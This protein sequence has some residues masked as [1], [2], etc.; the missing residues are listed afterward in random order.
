LARI[1]LL[2]AA[3]K[4]VA[5]WID[6]TFHVDSLSQPVS[7]LQQSPD[8]FYGPVVVDSELRTWTVNN[9]IV[10]VDGKSY[11]WGTAKSFLMWK[12]VVYLDNPNGLGFISEN[13]T[14]WNQPIPD[15]RIP[16]VI[17]PDPIPSMFTGTTK[18]SI[19]GNILTVADPSGWRVGDPLIIPAEQDRGQDGPGGGFPQTRLASTAA[20]SSLPNNTLFAVGE[21]VYLKD[22]AGKLVH[23]LND[24]GDWYTAKIVPKALTAKIT[25]I[26]GNKFTLNKSATVN[27]SDVDVFYDVGP[28]IVN[29]VQKAVAGTGPKARTVVNIEKLGIP[30]K[31]MAVGGPLAWFDK[32]YVELTCD[33]PGTVE[34]FS[35]KGAPCLSIHWRNSVGCVTKWITRR[36]NWGDKGFGLGWEGSTGVSGYHG[37]LKD[38][39][40]HGLQ[41]F[42][43]GHEFWECADCEDLDALTFDLPILATGGAGGSNCWSRRIKHRQNQPFR[44][45]IQWMI[46]YASGKNDGTEDC[47]IDSDSLIPGFE[48]MHHTGGT[49]IRPSGRNAIN[50][51]NNAGG[52]KVISPKFVF[53][54]GC[55][56]PL[57]G[58]PA[59][60]QYATGAGSGVPV[61][62]INRNA[63]GIPSVVAGGGTMTDVVIEQPG[64]L[65][66]R[67]SNLAGVVVD[68]EIV[69]FS[70][71]NLT[72]TFPEKR[73]QDPRYGTGAVGL[74]SY[75]P[76]A[77]IMGTIKVTGE[78]INAQNNFSIFTVGAQV[79]ATLES[80]PGSKSI[81]WKV[82]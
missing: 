31:K 42:L 38:T 79:T 53:D 57:E 67:G 46:Q 58:Y 43:A 40:A 82:S 64:Y 59:L 77:K 80:P 69:N 62:N 30:W 7:M 76:N 20:M 39:N 32:R 51:T 65:D 24:Y 75:G 61:W 9:N 29:A 22:T 36:G 18:G 1:H 44:Q 81:N 63:K 6:G 71:E 60:H 74:K 4:K 16:V 70:L 2:D 3:G 34:L 50:A 25:A 45:Y 73:V 19:V 26:N 21:D 10:Y 15:P 33:G 13:E 17:V 37:V 23:K 47:S 12:G 27:V 41:F 66:S 35:P 56:K 72:A 48:F 52:W 14:G 49:H 11:K 78:C 54:P 55:I 28:R 68:E 5:E 8:G